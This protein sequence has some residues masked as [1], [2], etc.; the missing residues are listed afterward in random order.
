[1]LL[2][3]LLLIISCLPSALG[4]AAATDFP[5]GAD[6]SQQCLL[7]REQFV[8]SSFWNF[9][10]TRIDDCLHRANCKNTYF[11]TSR[12][13]LSICGALY[14]IVSLRSSDLVAPGG[15]KRCVQRGSSR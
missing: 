11:A 12:D 6:C 7:V 15:E 13:L 5:Q 4:A 3:L 9:F 8:S 10:Q 14:F 1:V 2:L